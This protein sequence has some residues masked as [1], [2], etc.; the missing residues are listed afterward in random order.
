MQATTFTDNY[1]P[2]DGVS[3]S[4]VRSY[5]ATRA[6]S[7][8]AVRWSAALRSS[9][10][11]ADSGQDNIAPAP[12]Q[13][14]LT[15]PLSSNNIKSASSEVLPHDKTSELTTA[16]A[17]ESTTRGTGMALRSKYK[18]VIR[19]MDR[20]IRSAINLYRLFYRVT[21]CRQRTVL[22]AE[23]CPSL[24][25]SV[26]LCLVVPEVRY[27]VKSSITGNRKSTIGFPRNCHIQ[28]YISS[29]SSKMGLKYHNVTLLRQNVNCK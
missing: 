24:R 13:R 4:H 18:K 1:F 28:F 16:T 6:D 21:A 12:V 23:F 20:L 25:L 11:H 5:L 3:G 9:K 29:K 8:A 27:G 7:A 22:L 17:I 15:P 14:S 10:Y 2:V 26:T 19:L